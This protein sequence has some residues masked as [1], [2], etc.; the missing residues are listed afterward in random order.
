[1]R[2]FSVYVVL[3]LA[4]LA[5][6]LPAAAEHPQKPGKWQIKMQ[7][8]MPSMPIKMPPVTFD[9]CVTEEDL[10]DPQKSVPT[11]PKNPCTISDYKI[12]G[13]TVTYTMDCP[14]QKMKGKGEITY[15]GE[16]F[17]CIVD[18]T[19]Q[20]QEMSATYAGT[21]KGECTK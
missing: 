12:D 9:V 11:D 14:K 13:N 16:S 20:D 17:T 19:V 6:A 18:M 8:N 15:T 4:V 1:M 2:K 10:Q 5:M 7:M 3:A 21:W